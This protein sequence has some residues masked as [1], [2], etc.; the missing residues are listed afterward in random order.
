MAAGQMTRWRAESGMAAV[1]SRSPLCRTVWWNNPCVA[2]LLS[3][4]A[5]CGRAGGLAENGDVVGV[6]TEGNDVVGIQ[7]GAVIRS[8]TAKFPPASGWSKK[9]NAPSR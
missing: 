4:G 3:K 8:W 5:H 6:I 2:G 9:P 1:G 7:V